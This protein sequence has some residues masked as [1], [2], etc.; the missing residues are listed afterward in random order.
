MNALCSI[1]VLAVA[2]L[3]GGCA[4]PSR[5]RA[6]GDARVPAQALAEQVCSNCHGPR[7]LAV[8]DNFPHLAAQQPEYLEGQLRS[9]RERHRRDPG[10]YVYMWGIARGLSDAQITGLAAYYAAQPAPVA[11]PA[12]LVFPRDG[13]ALF[14]LGAP[15]RGVPACRTCHGDNGQGQG[16]F[17]RLAHQHGPYV[18]R[19]LEILREGGDNRPLGAVMNPV[20]HGLS[21]DDIRAVAAYIEGM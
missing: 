10:G 16:A 4:Q 1:A 17:P 2:C 3:A 21:D 12:G 19:Q 18:V 8:S 6:L 20:A 11:R 7:G 15:D 5:S 13:E 14:K 9:L